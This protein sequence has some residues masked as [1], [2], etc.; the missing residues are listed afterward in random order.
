MISGHWMGIAAIACKKTNADECSLSRF[1]GGIHYRLSV[2]EG[3]RLGKE[4][5]EL[6]IRRIKD[7]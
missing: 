7:K 3:I 4:M 1:Y 6:I 2:L 5:G